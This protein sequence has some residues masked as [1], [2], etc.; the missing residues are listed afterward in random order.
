MTR[1][2][3]GLQIIPDGFNKFPQP[4]QTEVSG[5]QKCRIHNIN[6]FGAGHGYGSLK[7]G[8]GGWQAVL[9]L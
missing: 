7:F 3:A 4:K 8:W 1:S 5:G 6:V 2:P 9:R